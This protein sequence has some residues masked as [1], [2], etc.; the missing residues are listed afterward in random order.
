MIDK[1]GVS[2]VIAILLLIV[3]AVASSTLFYVWFS[4]HVMSVKSSAE[5]DT[6]AL[7]YK[8]K[9]DGA[10]ISGDYLIVYVRNIGDVNA[11]VDIAYLERGGITQYAL[12][13]VNGTLSIP[14]N[15]VYKIVYNLPSGITPGSYSFK[16]GT[17][18]GVVASIVVGEQQISSGTGGGGDIWK[19]RR[20]IT[21][22]ENSGSTLTDYQIKVV[23]DTANFDYSHANSDGSDI[24]FKDSDDTTALSF[25]IEKWNP[26]GESIIWVKVPQI[27]A[28]STKTIYMYYGN[29][30]ASSASDGD[31]TFIFFDDFEGASLDGSKWTVTDS[32]AG[33]YSVSGGVLY[34]NLKVNNGNG[35]ALTIEAIPKFPYSSISNYVFE[36][37]VRANAV[38][39]PIYTWIL[40]G[41][42]VGCENSGGLE[43]DYKYLIGWEGYND[44]YALHSWIGH[45]ESNPV[46]ASNDVWYVYYLHISSSSNAVGCIGSSCASSTWNIGSTTNYELV[47]GG[48]GNSYVEY[49]FDWIRVRKYA[50]P[51]PTVSVGAEEEL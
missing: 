25:W 44:R 30:S 16:I 5:R 40:S 2:P 8:I 12:N 35:R 15:R 19:Y 49:W 9:I 37:Y 11:T 6:S 50:S 4:G 10:F 46:T 3:I 26:S 48:Q 20:A 7:S 13:P 34:I 18:S 45:M 39:N 42:G 23:L 43:W 21:I 51:E 1:R 33:S 29:P 22:T 27:P 28:G 38:T 41:M 24:R 47:I 31:A 32:N 36:S 14:P 17:T